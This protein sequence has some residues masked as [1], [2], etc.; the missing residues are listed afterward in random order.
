MNILFLTTQLPYPPISGGVIKSWKLVEHWGSGD[1]ELTVICP[2]KND[3]KNNAE[4]FQKALPKVKL[5]SEEIERERSAL[6]LIKSYFLSDTLNVYRNYHPQLKKKIDEV[7]PK[8]DVVIIDHYEMGQYVEGK[9]SD[10]TILHEHNAEYVMWD[11][12]AEFESNPLKKFLIRAESSRIKRTE[13][14]Y[15]DRSSLIWA[16][17]NDIIELEKLGIAKSKCRTTYHLGEDEM[18]D[19]PELKF[20][21]TEESLLFVGTLTWEANVDGL[22]WFINEVWPKLIEEKPDLTFNIIGKNPDPRIK[23]LA[24]E[25]VGINLT[26]FVEDLEPYHRRARVFVIPLRFGSGIKVK[27]INAMYRGLPTVTTAVGTE[28]LDTVNGKHLFETSSPKEQAESVLKLLDDANLWAELSKNC[29]QLSKNY[30]W[31]SLLSRHDAEI[32]EIIG[33]P[34]NEKFVLNQ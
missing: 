15:A 10:K 27:L 29:R 7:I 12:L 31:K 28:G 30:T 4:A 5:I 18:L 3:D 32:S 34:K 17:P 23:A 1:H 19:W 8:A 11:R 16:A 13:E 2:F 9:Y 20:E 6:N 24:D 25:Y 33:N 22:Q 21:D 14:K 26:G